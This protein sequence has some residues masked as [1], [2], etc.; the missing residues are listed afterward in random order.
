MLYW[1]VMFLV[2]AVIAAIFGFG[3]ITTAALGIA[4]ILFFLFLVLFV[5]TL[6]LGLFQRRGSF[7]ATR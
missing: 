4:K 5:V 6:V 2:V 3:G 1:S 7:R